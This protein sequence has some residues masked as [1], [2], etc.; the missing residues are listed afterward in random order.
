M[1]FQN[2]AGNQRWLFKVVSR[3]NISS[4][5]SETHATSLG[6]PVTC[7][8][9]HIPEH[10]STCVY[11]L[12]MIPLPRFSPLLGNCSL[13]LFDW[14][15]MTQ[16][17]PELYQMP[18]CPWGKDHCLLVIEKDS[19]FMISSQWREQNKNKTIWQGRK[20]LSKRQPLLFLSTLAGNSW[21]VIMG[22]YS[23][24]FC[25]PVFSKYSSWKI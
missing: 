6:M 8:L 17:P 20:T 5:Y 12:L 15:L 22:L 11:S 14:T 24:S 21:S 10:S 23:W 16:A 13:G 3:D 2:L 7:W 1:C 19:V 4:S 9:S 18:F 25:T